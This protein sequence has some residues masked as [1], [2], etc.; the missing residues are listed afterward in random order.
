MV[1]VASANAASSAAV[2]RLPL[3]DRFKTA[4]AASA[5]CPGGTVVW[6]SLSKSK[7]FHLSG[8]RY[9]G[10]TKHGAY[11]CKSDALQFGFHQ[12]RS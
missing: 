1:P 8:S 11:V 6:S 5:H 7:S 10:T 2:A 4:A 9:Y 3:S 12:A